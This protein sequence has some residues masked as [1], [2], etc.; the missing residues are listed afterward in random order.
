MTVVEILDRVLPV[1][2]AEVAAFARKQ[3]EKRG[4]KFK[5]G[6]KVKSLTKN[7]DS[8]SVTIE[9]AGAMESL[10]VERVISAVGVQG[11]IENLGLGS[12]QREGREGMRCRGPIW[13]HECGR[14]LRN[15]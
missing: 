3:L 7:S 4:I 13:S 1:E 15:R 14:R 2:D 8:V 10:V 5:V 6:S 9:G 11:N 12:A